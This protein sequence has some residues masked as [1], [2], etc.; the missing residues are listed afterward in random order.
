MNKTEEAQRHFE[1]ITKLLTAMLRTTVANPSD[2][3]VQ[4]GL[5]RDAAQIQGQG[6][7]LPESVVE[8]QKGFL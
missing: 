5:E 1:E 7:H 2:S 6:T 3:C 8:E 4:D